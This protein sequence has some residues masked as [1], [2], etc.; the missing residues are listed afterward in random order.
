MSISPTIYD[1]AAK[2]G[3]SVSTVSLALNAPSR[4]RG[5][6]LTGF[7]TRIDDP[8][9]FRRPRPSRAHAVASDASE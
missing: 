9:S 1:V 5:E 4:V 8:G 3:V 6:T 2:A 7:T